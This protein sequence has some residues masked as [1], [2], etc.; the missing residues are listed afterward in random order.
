M[1]LQTNQS[2]MVARNKYCNIFIQRIIQL[3]S[4]KLI[5]SSTE[6]LNEFKCSEIA[7]RSRTV[8]GTDEHSKINVLTLI[9]E[10]S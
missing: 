5:N 7:L 10:N 8:F 3:N 9:G 6:I 4:I 1:E 2:S